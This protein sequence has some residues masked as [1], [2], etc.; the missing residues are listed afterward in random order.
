ML[1][2]G[3][4]SRSAAARGSRRRARSRSRSRSAVMSEAQTAVVRPRGGARLRRS[5]ACALLSLML[6]ACSSGSIP[7][8]SDAPLAPQPEKQKLLSASEQR[9]HL[10]ILAAYGG[11]YREPRVQDMLEKTV[12]KL[13]AASERPELR[14][15]VRSEEHTSE[16]QSPDHLVC[17]LLL[18][19]KKI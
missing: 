14:Y 12:D 7:R 4:R 9:E 16:L 18:E 1:G 8:L 11:I 3:A 15:E 17:R 2:C 13:V 10:R 19:K 6:A 5:A